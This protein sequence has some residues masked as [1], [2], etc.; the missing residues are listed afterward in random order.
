MSEEQTALVDQFALFVNTLSAR[1]VAGL[2]SLHLGIVSTDLGSGGLIASC[3]GDGD[4]GRLLALP[5]TGGCF[6]PTG[7]YVVDIADPGGSRTRNYVGDLS[8]T[9]ACIAPLGTSGCGFQQPLAAVQA[10]LGGNPAN[11]GFLRP[12]AFLAVVI[13]TDEDDCS[14]SN[15]ALFDPANTT[16][17]ALTDFRCTEQGVSC[18]GMNLTRTAA[19]YATC[20]PR[21][22]SLLADPRSFASFVRGLKTD[23]CRVLVATIAGPPTPFSVSLVSGE[24]VL[25]ASCT[26]IAGG[27]TPAVRLRDFSSQFPDR[28]LT[29]NVCQD[30][31]LPAIANAIADAMHAP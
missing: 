6:G 19:T 16:L 2:P 21:T 22:D 3:P 24:P 14:A 29:Q 4:G 5:R 10:A 27:A 7:S 15:D 28:N 9:F 11:T 12:D 13:L 30:L 17:G 20:E 31:G 8:S 18:D 1:F 26:S 23:A 25:D